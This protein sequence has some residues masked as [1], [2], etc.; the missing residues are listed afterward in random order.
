L[1][2]DAYQVSLSAGV[3]LICLEGKYGPNQKWVRDPQTGER[4]GLV[5]ITKCI[6]YEER[7]AVVVKTRYQREPVI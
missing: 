4:V 1:D 7:L 5:P 2:P 6:E 3:N